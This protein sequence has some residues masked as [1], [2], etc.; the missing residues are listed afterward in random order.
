MKTKIII[1]VGIL[2]LLIGYNLY[3]PHY[4]DRNMKEYFRNNEE[5]FN[6]LAKM[7]SE[8]TQINSIIDF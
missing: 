2:F 1:V 5:D 4:S 6:K 8:D 7:F 3:F